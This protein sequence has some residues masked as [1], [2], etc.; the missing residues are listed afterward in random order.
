MSIRSRIGNA[1]RRLGLADGACR[2][3][4]RMPGVP[5]ALVIQP[6]GR[7]MPREEV[8]RKIAAYGNCSVCGMPPAMVPT[9]K[10][11]SP[12]P[13]WPPPNLEGGPCTD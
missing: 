13:P 11:D 10:P 3:C 7:E 4:G 2:G 9:I 6:I 8:E 5:R 12:A 1:E